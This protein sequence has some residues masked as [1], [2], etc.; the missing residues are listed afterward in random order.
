V[1][2]DSQV[3]VV[4]EWMFNNPNTN[5]SASNFNS[6][7][8]LFNDLGLSIDDFVDDLNRFTAIAKGNMSILAA[9]QLSE[10]IS[11]FSNILQ[12]STARSSNS[13]G[14]HVDGSID[15]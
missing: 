5:L 3:Q 1:R 2:A 11:L 7:A 9:G 6:T 10:E 4:Y 15:F 8:Y 14:H 13:L 12:V